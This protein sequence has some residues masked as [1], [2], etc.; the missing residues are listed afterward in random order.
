MASRHNMHTDTQLLPG[1]RKV[2]IT[3]AHTVPA[4]PSLD[5]GSG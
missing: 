1:P 5:D 4:F 3:D 2:G